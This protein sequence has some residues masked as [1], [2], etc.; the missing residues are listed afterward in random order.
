MLKITAALQ[1]ASMQA[2]TYTHQ[3]THTHTLI[4]REALLK[5]TPTTATTHTNI[6]QCCNESTSK[7]STLFHQKKTM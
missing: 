6:K 5:A 2:Y 3:P 4:H 1:Q 7:S